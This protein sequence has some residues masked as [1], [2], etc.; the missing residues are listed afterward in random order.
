[1]SL[2][3]AQA[4]R[5][6]L[7][8]GVAVEGLVPLYCLDEQEQRL[9]VLV[10]ALERGDGLVDVAEADMCACQVQRFSARALC[11]QFR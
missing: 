7:E 6:I 4:P 1:M 8:A 11:Q 2:R 10:R 3:Q 5:E 9:P